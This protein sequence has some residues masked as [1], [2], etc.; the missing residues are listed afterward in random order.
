MVKSKHNPD[1]SEPMARRYPLAPPV[2]VQNVV[3]S[4]LSQFP[5]VSVRDSSELWVTECS[6]LVQYTLDPGEAQPPN[7]LHRL[8]S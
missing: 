3:G 2:W 4:G 7:D 6:C 8:F 1:R 5:S